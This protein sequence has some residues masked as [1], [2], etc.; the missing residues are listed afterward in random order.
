MFRDL[1]PGVLNFIVSKS[2]KRSFTLNRAS[3]CAIDL[4]TI[5]RCVRDLKTFRVNRYR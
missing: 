2:L 1:S 3:K 4:T 5:S